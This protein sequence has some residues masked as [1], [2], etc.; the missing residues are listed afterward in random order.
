MNVFIGE[1]NGFYNNSLYYSDTDSLYIEKK[2]WEVWDKAILV[3]GILCQGKNDLK[4][5]FFQRI[6][7][8]P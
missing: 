8:S 6:V 4:N 7:S 3:G 1:I 2:Y 5:G